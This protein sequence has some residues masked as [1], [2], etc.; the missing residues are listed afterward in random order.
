MKNSKQR[1]LFGI[2]LCRHLAII[3]TCVVIISLSFLLSE[4]LAAPFAATGEKPIDV[5]FNNADTDGNGLISEVE[6]HT[7]MQ[8]RLENIDTNHDGNISREELEKSKETM[9]ENFRNLRKR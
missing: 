1:I 3:L 6:W 5:F 7:A 9:R 8:K 2:N 4:S